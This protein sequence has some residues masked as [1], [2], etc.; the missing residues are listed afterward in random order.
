M[1]GPTVHPPLLN[2]LGFLILSIFTGCAVGPDYRT[3]ESGDL[4]PGPMEHREES[5][6]PPAEWWMVLQDP[7]LKDLLA[8]ADNANRDLRIA[9]T[10][11]REARAGLLQAQGGF[12]PSLGAAASAS[13]QRQS[14]NGVLLSSLPSVAGNIDPQTSLYRVGFDASWELD[15]F[16]RTR[17]GVEAARARLES[18]EEASNLA[19]QSVMAELVLNYIQLRGLQERRII[20]LRNIEVQED[21]LDLVRDRRSSGLGNDLAVSQARSQLL[22]TRA[23]LPGLEAGVQA[24]LHAISTLVGSPPRALPESLETFQELP[25]LPSHLLRYIPANVIQRRPD[26]RLA[27][28]QLR[29]ESAEIGQ[30]MADQWPTF[31]LTGGFAFEST[32][33][34]NLFDAASRTWSIGPGLQWPIFSANRISANIDRQEA[35]YE[36]ALANYEQSVL[37]AFQ[38]VETVL[39]QNIQQR[40]TSRRLEAA[41]EETARSL[42]LSKALYE[43][44]LADF[45]SVLNAERQLVLIE[46]QLIQSRTREWTAFIRLYKALGGGWSQPPE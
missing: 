5:L 38:E 8:R 29:A 39:A 4:T 10:R 35:Q 30:A 3:P 15:W 41:T 21:T 34:G 14:E 22:T 26:I 42:E 27:E 18:A 11:I 31:S 24:R 40:E 36:G 12:L 46:D 1:T 43:S 25:A 28:R 6:S 44:G 19:R 20:L 17:R 23:S 16:G 9:N 2:L 33:T 37:R 7:V 32:D 45:L 13:E